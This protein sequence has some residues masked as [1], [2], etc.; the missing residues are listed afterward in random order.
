MVLWPAEASQQGFR[1]P[2][3]DLPVG[4]ADEVG[5]SV[6]LRVPVLQGSRR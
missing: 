4:A 1:V 6:I 2:G 3:A 5:A